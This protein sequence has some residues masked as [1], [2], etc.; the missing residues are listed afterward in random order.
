[1]IIVLYLKFLK[2]SSIA[3][4]LCFYKIQHKNPWSGLHMNPSKTDFQFHFI[5]T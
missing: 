3:Y 1:M 2:D 5:K 4:A